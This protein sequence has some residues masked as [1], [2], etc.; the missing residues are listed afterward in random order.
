MESRLYF[1]CCSIMRNWR[2]RWSH[3]DQHL[4]SAITTSA[5]NRVSHLVSVFISC[6]FYNHLP[7]KKQHWYRA[8]SQDKCDNHH[9]YRQRPHSM[10]PFQEM[11]LMWKR[12]THT[13]YWLRFMRNFLFFSTLAIPGIWDPWPSVPRSFIGWLNRP[14]TTRSATFVPISWHLICQFIFSWFYWP[15]SLF[16]LLPFSLS[17]RS[18]IASMVDAP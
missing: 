13:E 15:C 10:F 11:W 17:L 1:S 7:Q 14:L 18:G 9:S 2:V 5:S 4:S 16:K 12:K 6:Q 3:K 8:H